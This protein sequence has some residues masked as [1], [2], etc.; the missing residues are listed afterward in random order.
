MSRAGFL[1]EALEQGPDSL[2]VGFLIVAV[3]QTRHGA[4]RVPGKVALIELLA[5][6]ERGERRVQREAEQLYAAARIGVGS[7]VE[8]LDIRFERPFSTFT[9]FRPSSERGRMRSPPGALFQVGICD[10]GR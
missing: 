6:R 9:Y 4:N 1:L 7:L 8:V 3:V 2:E 10:S 5:R